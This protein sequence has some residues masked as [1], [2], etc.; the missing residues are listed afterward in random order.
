[1]HVVNCTGLRRTDPRSV[2]GRDKLSQHPQGV[3]IFRLVFFVFS[4]LFFFFFFGV[5]GRR[6]R[7]KKVRKNKGRCRCWAGNLFS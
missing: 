4:I 7:G 3:M 5:L 2:W 6:G 1:V